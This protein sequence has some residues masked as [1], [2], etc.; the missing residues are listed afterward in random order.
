MG[1]ISM[2]YFNIR[3]GEVYRLND[4]L[5]NFVDMLLKLILPCNMIVLCK[6]IIVTSLPDV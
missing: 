3:K 4:L 5:C 2:Y 6:L 1:Y